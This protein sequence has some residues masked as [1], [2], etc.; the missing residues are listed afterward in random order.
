MASSTLVG[1]YKQEKHVFSTYSLS[2]A[3][4][5]CQNLHTIYSD[6]YT[7]LVHNP[8]AFQNLDHIFD[9]ICLPGLP[10]TLGGRFAEATVLMTQSHHINIGPHK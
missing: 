10:P 4:Y 3:V 7:I 5:T 1:L 2:F 8:G 6:A 9:R